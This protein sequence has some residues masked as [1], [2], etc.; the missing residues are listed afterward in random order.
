[1][2]TEA[3]G[4]GEICKPKRIRVILLGAFSKSVPY[5]E[6]TLHARQFG[7]KGGI[8]PTSGKKPTTVDEHFV[9]GS[10]S[11]SLPLYLSFPF[12]TLSA[13]SSQGR[14]TVASLRSFKA[15]AILRGSVEEREDEGGEDPTFPARP[16][17]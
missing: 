4:K 15:V 2:G 17:T 12:F 1:M 9:N 10:L 6:A 14:T 13:L 3:V 11:L 7:G 16:V 5:P 8:H